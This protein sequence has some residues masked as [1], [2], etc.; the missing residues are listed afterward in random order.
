MGSKKTLLTP[1]GIIDFL[2]LDSA[3]PKCDLRSIYQIEVNEFRCKIGMKLYERLCECLAEY[4][5]EEYVSGTTYP[6]GSV[7]VYKGIYYKA[8]KETDSIPSDISCW[9]KAPKFSKPCL[10]EL[11]CMFLGE[12]LAAAVLINQLPK[13]FSKLKHGTIVK[14]FGDGFQTGDE[15]DLMIL[16]N[17]YKS[18][19]ETILMNMD[20][21]INENNADGCYDGYLGLR[22]PKRK[23][24]RRRSW[25][26][27]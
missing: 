12:Y 26:A 6:E 7:V 16:I 25:D 4:P 23:I 21:W 13:L 24:E 2:G 27:A 19:K 10:E 20:A 11:W 17:S 9:E 8:I 3:F 15:K 22:K 5:C 1:S 18:D 14:L